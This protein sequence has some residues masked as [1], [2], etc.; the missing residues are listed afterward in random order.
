M[1]EQ[2]HYYIKTQLINHQGV[3]LINWKKIN[4]N[5]NKI[6]KLRKT[7]DKCLAWSWIIFEALATSWTWLVE[8]PS[9]L[10]RIL[11]EKPNRLNSFIQQ[12]QLEREKTLDEGTSLTTSSMVWHPYHMTHTSTYNYIN[13][14]TQGSG[15]FVLQRG[16]CPAEVKKILRFFQGI[17]MYTSCTWSC[18]L[19]EIGGQHIPNYTHSKSLHN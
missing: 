17:I 8:R 15:Y 3:E 1:L 6:T 19:V 16:N 18:H 11:S 13:F 14:P 5:N 9:P 4:K 2:L 10:W 12:D 7:L